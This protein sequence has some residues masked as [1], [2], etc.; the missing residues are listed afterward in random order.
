MSSAA[1]ADLPP[2]FFLTPSSAFV[3][4]F[5]REPSSAEMPK[6]M[7]PVPEGDLVSATF[8]IVEGRYDEIVIENSIEKIFAD[9]S[10]QILAL[11][12][13]FAVCLQQARIEAQDQTDLVTLTQEA[14]TSCLEFAEWVAENFFYKRHLKL[15]STGKLNGGADFIA[16]HQKTGKRLDI[17]FEP[18]GRSASI[19]LTDQKH[20]VRRERFE[21]DRTVWNRYIQWLF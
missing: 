8:S 19:F 20:R 12:E 15:I 5:E 4:Q 9:V 3:E 6:F 16:V 7:L 11:K 17:S 14:E 10:D 18:D 1:S 13:R 21:K 2:V